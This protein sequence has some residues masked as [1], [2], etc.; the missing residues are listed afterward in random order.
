MRVARPVYG[1]IKVRR[2][3]LLLDMG[4]DNALDVRKPL[5]RLAF[6]ELDIA[7]IS[8]L[9]FLQVDLGR[10]APKFKIWRHHIGGLEIEEQARKRFRQPLAQRPM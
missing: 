2:V 3:K 6:A 5:L 9:G 7:W 8:A 10:A 1:E 4:V